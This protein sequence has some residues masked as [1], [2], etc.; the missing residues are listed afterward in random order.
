M[1]DDRTL[2]CSGGLGCT[3]SGSPSERICT[4]L[5][6]ECECCFNRVNHELSRALWCLARLPSVARV[7]DLFL[8]D[9]RGSAQILADGLNHSSKTWNMCGFEMDKAKADTAAQN[10][11]QYGSA[12]VWNGSH[13]GASSQ[14]TIVNSV[15]PRHRLTARVL[16]ALCREKPDLVFLDPFSTMEAEILIAHKY[17][18]PAMYLVAN[19]NLGSGSGWFRN[20][21]LLK[22]DWAEVLT[23]VAPDLYATQSAAGKTN[24]L[25]PYGRD[26][27]ALRTWSLLVRDPVAQSRKGS[28]DGVL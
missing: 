8:G 6:S 27:L 3:S 20:Y 4:A 21:L 5:N 13:V 24:T 9:G 10:L 17:C 23:G 7:V 28:A 11:R 15:L 14:I 25:G 2:G 16:Q 19:T 12:L 1:E 22:N 26:L 18:T